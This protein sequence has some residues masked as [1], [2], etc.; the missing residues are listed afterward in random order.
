MRK[1]SF[2][3]ALAI[4]V[5]FLSAMLAP[6]AANA[7]SSDH[8]DDYGYVKICK[9][10]KNYYGQDKKFRFEIEGEHY[11]KYVWVKGGECSDKYKVD[12][13]DYKITE[14]HKD[15]WKLYDIYGDYYK[16]NVDKSWATVQ[17]KH[18]YTYK[19]TFYNK[20]YEHDD[21]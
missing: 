2:G 11:D 6:A 18:P 14:Y 5:A 10:I 12:F 19:V 17:V 3:A 1:F 15:H 20:Y 16:K 4:L 21:N 9:R 8:H 13:G 7:S